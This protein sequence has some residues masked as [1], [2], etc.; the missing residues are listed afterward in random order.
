M[1]LQEVS[2]HLSVNLNWPLLMKSSVSS[3]HPVRFYAKTLY[4]KL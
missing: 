2:G 3:H 4:D 1:S